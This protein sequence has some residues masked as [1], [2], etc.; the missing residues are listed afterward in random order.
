MPGVFHVRT[1]WGC[2]SIFSRTGVQTPVSIRVFSHYRFRWS[3]REC[4]LIEATF[5]L[6]W[7][8]VAIGL[9]ETTYGVSVL[10][11]CWAVHLSYRQQGDWLW[12]IFKSQSRKHNQ[13]LGTQE[14]LCCGWF[15]SAPIQTQILNLWGGKSQTMNQTLLR[16]AAL[17]LA[18]VAVAI[19]LPQ[20]TYSVSWLIT[21]RRTHMGLLSEIA[22]KKKTNSSIWGWRSCCV[23]PIWVTAG[24]SMTM[25][26]LQRWG[27]E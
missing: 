8:T 10:V 3:A 7:V 11:A 6:A 20:S 12:Q 15:H 24:W 21:C 27:F 22:L 2:V 23:T 16:D 26:V 4:Q 14:M 1:T 19:D 5:P 18:C 9:P 13:D 25:R 17:T